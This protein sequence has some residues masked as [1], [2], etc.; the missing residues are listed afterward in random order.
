MRSA[1]SIYLSEQA[2]GV[3]ADGILQFKEPL[4]F[5]D[6]GPAEINCGFDTH[7]LDVFRAE[8][9]LNIDP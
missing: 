1:I 8:D 9:L 4:L 2:P 6:S 5:P 3:G 7:I